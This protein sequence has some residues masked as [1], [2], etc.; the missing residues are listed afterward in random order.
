MASVSGKIKLFWFS[1]VSFV[2]L[3]LLDFLFL[4][5]SKILDL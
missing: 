4:D 1:I 2:E 5:V 3:F